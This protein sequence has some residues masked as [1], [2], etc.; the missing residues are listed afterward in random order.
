MKLRQICCHPRLLGEDH[1]SGGSAKFD[2]LVDLLETFREEGHRVLV[3]SQ[4]TTMLDLIEAHL[5]A[6]EV[7]YL[8]LTGATKDRQSLVERFQGGEGEVFLISLK[9]GGTGLTLTGADTVIH[10]DPWWNP[11]AEN[12]ATDRAYRIG[13]DKPVFV[14]KLICRSTVEE[15]IQLMQEKKDDI[16]SDLL[17]G[18]ATGIDLSPETMAGLLGDF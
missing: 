12:Q 14:H 11:A 16:A 5:I 6:E 7:S 18:A 3:F 1:A 10:Y 13:Q 4:F 15:R 8:K 9:A 2:Y 17:S